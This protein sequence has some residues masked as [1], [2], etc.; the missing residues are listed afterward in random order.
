[1]VMLREKD[2][3]TI[4]LEIGDKAKFQYLKQPVTDDENPQLVNLVETSEVYFGEIIDVRDTAKNPVTDETIRRGNIKGHRSRNLIFV[5]LADG[6]IKSFY[7][8]RMVL[9]SLNKQKIILRFAKALLRKFS[10]N[11][12]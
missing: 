1:M 5:K 2:K 10:K 4:M 11:S 8:G 12:T 9:L 6:S 7:D 3:E